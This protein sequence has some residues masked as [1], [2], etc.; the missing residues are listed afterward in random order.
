MRVWV[1]LN[2]MGTGRVQLECLR[3]TNDHGRVGTGCS[4]A[5]FNPNA[6]AEVY[7]ILQKLGVDEELAAQKI[8]Q[9]REAVPG[10]VVKVE[11]REIPEDLLRENGF[12]GF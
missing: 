10:D 3:S 5:P 8:I 6:L 9:I 12:L 7:T 4:L 1:L 2:K 11:D